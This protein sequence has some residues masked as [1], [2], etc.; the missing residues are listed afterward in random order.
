MPELLVLYNRD[1]I[2]NEIPFPVIVENWDKKS[3][4]KV[5]RA[6]YA[7]FDEKE[8]H[9]IACYISRF[10][11]WYLVKGTPEKCNFTFKN[12]AVIQ[13]AGNFFASI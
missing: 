3:F 10:R 2:N 4:G 8:R 11:N 7:E 6:Y 1:E 13:R 12:I 9:T 5:K